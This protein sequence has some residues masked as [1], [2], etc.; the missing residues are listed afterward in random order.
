MREEWLLSDLHIHTTFS[1]GTM[2]ISDVID[3]YG[4]REFDAIAIT[5]HMLD[6]ISRNVP[7]KFIPRNWIKTEDE[8]RLYYNTI[9]EE[10]ERAKE[11]YNMV[12]IPGIEF[13][14]YISNIHIVGL[15]IKQYIK[16]EMKTIQSLIIA[17]NQNML[18]IGAHPYNEKFFRMGGG[19]WKNKEVSAY[20]DIW[21]AGN[22]VDFFPHVIQNKC[23]FIANTDFHGE[24]RENGING[25]KTII[26][27][28]RTIE[29]I[30]KAIMDNKVAIH[31][32]KD[33]NI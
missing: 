18:L 31:K 32:Y 21:E 4:K 14:N 12:V 27:A 17:K 8:F 10:A 16:L 33:G 19:L 9:L 6:P 30:K 24:K 13:T 1:D 15:D 23:R 7:R 11:K 2:D 3:F 25:W 29:S 5:D 20:I 26:K 28:E 22:G